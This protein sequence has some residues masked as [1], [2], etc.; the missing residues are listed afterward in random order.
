MDSE[1]S[2]DALGVQND[3]ECAADKDT[4]SL[5]SPIVHTFCSLG[6]M[7]DVFIDLGSQK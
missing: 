1:G 7:V 5:R 3:K 2:E 4:M 6:P